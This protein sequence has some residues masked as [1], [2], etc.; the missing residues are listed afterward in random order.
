M[1]NAGEVA[2]ESDVVVFWCPRCG[3]I[4]SRHQGDGKP[5]VPWLVKGVQSF[6]EELKS[7]EH[8]ALIAE[9]VTHGLAES[10]QELP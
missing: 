7:P 6:R 2:E 9:F 1:Q 3:T 8:D 4:K 5:Y 10:T